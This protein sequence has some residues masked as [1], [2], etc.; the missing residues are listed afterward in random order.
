MAMGTVVEVDVVA[1]TDA[2]AS[3]AAHAAVA[4][5]K[6][7]DDVL[8]TW[9][10]S[11]ELAQFNKRAGQGFIPITSDLRLGLSEMLRY[12]R[13]TGGAFDPAVGRLV[14]ARRLHPDDAPSPA[15]RE[16]SIEQALSMRARR[17]RLAPGVELDPGGIGKGIALDAALREFRR[18]AVRAAFI[19]FG[20]SSQVA[21][22]AAAGDAP[23]WGMMVAGLAPGTVHGVLRLVDE[24]L[25]TSRSP[26]T[27]DAGLI[28]DPRSGRSIV[29]TRLAVVRAPTG[30]AADAWSTALV[31][32]GRPGLKRAAAAGVEALVEDDAGVVTT[33]DFWRERGSR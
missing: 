19:N 16:R 24:H 13:A 29:A 4:A 32:L 9:R 7:W 5:I 17:A 1:D 26:G 6:H 18:A 30:A 3:D 33:P 25:S 11:G 12:F 23:G 10:E 22:G 28:F 20:G 31:V 27:A 21:V 15:R 2:A 8:T 14:S